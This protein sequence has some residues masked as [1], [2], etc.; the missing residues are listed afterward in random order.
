MKLRVSLS[1]KQVYRS[2][3]ECRNFFRSNINLPDVHGKV[4]L[5]KSNLEI[6]FSKLSTM[7]YVSTI[8]SLLSASLFLTILLQFK[9]CL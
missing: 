8:L 2:N 7:R 3:I 5:M 9:Y 1:K 4:R 6:V